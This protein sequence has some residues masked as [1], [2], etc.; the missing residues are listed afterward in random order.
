MSAVAVSDV[1][2]LIALGKIDEVRAALLTLPRSTINEPQEGGINDGRTMLMMAAAKGHADIV[3][4]LLRHGADMSVQDNKGVTA[5]S[6]AR[7][8]G[9]EELATTISEA[10]VMPAL[11]ATFAA[12]PSTSTTPGT[13]LRAAAAEFVPP[14]WMATAAQSHDYAYWGSEDGLG[15][16]DQMAPTD[17]VTLPQPAPHAGRPHRRSD[18]RARPGTH[19]S[20]VSEFDLTFHRSWLGSMP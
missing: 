9:H 1:R 12:M 3:R 19:H 7:K 20:H 11:K 14:A 13:A 15:E 18:T 10:P 16:E 5:E 6:L 8:Q 17:E 4:E 2:N